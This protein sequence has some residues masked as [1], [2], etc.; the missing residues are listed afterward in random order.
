MRQ[1]PDAA[2]HRLVG[3]ALV[4]L[5][6]VVLMGYLLSTALFAAASLA[7]VGKFSFILAGLGATYGLLPRKQE[8]PCW[9]P[10]ASLVK[11][12]VCS[13]YVVIRAPPHHAPQTSPLLEVYTSLPYSASLR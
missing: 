3:K 9:M 13:G 1:T 4:A 8:G 12:G 6:I 7:Q 2:P 5:G 11:K 10:G